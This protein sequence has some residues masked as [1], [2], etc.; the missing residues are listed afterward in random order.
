MNKV[1]VGLLKANEG[2][3]L[4]KT[5]KMNIKENYG[6]LRKTIF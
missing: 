3:K 4:K 5:I 1:V 2:N 6:T